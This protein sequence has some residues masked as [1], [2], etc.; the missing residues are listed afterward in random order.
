[1]SQI[2]VKTSIMCDSRLESAA[3]YAEVTKAEIYWQLTRIWLACHDR[4]RGVLTTR[5]LATAMDHADKLVVIRSLWQATLLTSPCDMRPIVAEEWLTD[6]SKIDGFHLNGE[7]V[8]LQ[9]FAVDTDLQIRADHYLYVNGTYDSLMRVKLW[10]QKKVDAGKL[11]GKASAEARRRKKSEAGEGQANVNDRQAML[12]SRSGLSESI[13][14]KSNDR[15]AMLGSRSSSSTGQRPSSNAS[16]L[17]KNEA[18]VNDRQAMLGSRSVTSKIEKMPNSQISQSLGEAEVNDRQAMLGCGASTASKRNDCQANS[19]SVFSG[20]NEPREAEADAPEGADHAV[21]P[22]TPLDVGAVQNTNPRDH[23]GDPILDHGMERD[24]EW[25]SQVAH[26]AM[27]RFTMRGRKPVLLKNEKCHGEIERWSAYVTGAYAAG[28][29]MS[30]FAEVDIT[31]LRPPSKLVLS[32]LAK[33]LVY[34]SP[35]NGLDAGIRFLGAFTQAALLWRD[36]GASFWLPTVDNFLVTQA[37]YKMLE[38]KEK[39][40]RMPEWGPKG[41]CEWSFDFAD[42]VFSGEAQRE[43][44]VEN[45]FAGFYGG[46]FQT[47]EQSGVGKDTIIKL[48]PLIPVELE[49]NSPAKPEAAVPVKATKTDL[50]STQADEPM[51]MYPPM[52]ERKI[53]PFVPWG[54][55]PSQLNVNGSHWP[56]DEN[57]VGSQNWDGSEEGDYESSPLN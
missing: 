51:V 47:P 40:T 48:K 14:S 43:W 42:M 29:A 9:S 56:G 15:Q 11:G 26:L 1:M 45:V 37:K 2:I 50:E 24:A 44:A 8:L 21:A 16:G 30:C 28:V 13:L 41:F 20:S 49:S 54:N 27:A 6:W 22:P 23:N 25:F 39:P 32:K 38:R 36:T 7:Q 17:L 33:L 12:G 53:E 4:K 18:E 57:W 19:N 3:Q 5:E 31:E 10:Q 52:T 55:T 34:A 35:R 46:I